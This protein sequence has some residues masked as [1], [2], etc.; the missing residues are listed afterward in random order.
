[1]STTTT[2]TRVIR[3]SITSTRGTGEV[4]QSTGL[5]LLDGTPVDGALQPRADVLP[6]KPVPEAEGGVSVP[7]F[8]QEEYQRAVEAK[9]FATAARVVEEHQNK[10]LLAYQGGGASSSIE[11]RVLNTVLDYCWHTLGYA[12]TDDPNRFVVTREDVVLVKAT[13]VME[14]QEVEVFTVRIASRFGMG[15]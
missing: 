14:G 12:P 6:M 2:Q 9:D 3:L 4:A 1:M 11:E 13:E 15:R 8:P 10:M 7:E 5:F